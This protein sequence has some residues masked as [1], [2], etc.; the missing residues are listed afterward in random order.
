MTID[1]AASILDITEGHLKDLIRDGKLR[2]RITGVRWA[3]TY[4][5]N[6]NDVRRRRRRLTRAAR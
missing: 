5:V 1:D 4:V 3:R 6:G 2:A